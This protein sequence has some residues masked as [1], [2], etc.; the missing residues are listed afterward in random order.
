[1]LSKLFIPGKNWGLSLAELVSF[2]EAKGIKFAVCSFSKEFFVVNI[3]EESG[4][5]A[6]ADLGGFIK[7]G[8]A[9]ATKRLKRRLTGTL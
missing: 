2:L 6:I 5:W 7:I 3:E 8:D 4:C 9:T 1:M